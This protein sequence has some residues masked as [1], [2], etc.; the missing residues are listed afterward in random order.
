VPSRL[1]PLP[2]VI[3]KKAPRTLRQI[4]PSPPSSEVPPSTIAV[5]T[6]NSMPLFAS[7]W[8]VETCETRMTPAMP[9]DSPEIAKV[10]ARTRLM[11]TPERRAA[12]AL[13]PTA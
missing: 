9:P 10:E 6:S 7:H 4:A 13:P 12:S 5:M 1:K 2:I 8:A 3:R 11:R